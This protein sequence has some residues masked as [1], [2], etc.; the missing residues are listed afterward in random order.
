MTPQRGWHVICE[1]NSAYPMYVLTI[2]PQ[3]VNIYDD[4]RWNIVR[5]DEANRVAWARQVV[6]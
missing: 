1:D 4:R 2:A 5:V 3:L 6:A